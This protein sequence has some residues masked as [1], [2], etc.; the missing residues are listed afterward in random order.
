MY[1]QAAQCQCH[2]QHDISNYSHYKLSLRLMSVDQLRNYRLAEET[3]TARMTENGGGLLLC[4]WPV[5]FF[6]LSSDILKKFNPSL[7]GF[8]RG[9]GSKRKGFNMAVAGAKTSYVH[10]PSSSTR[11]T[12]WDNTLSFLEWLLPVFV[13]LQRDPSASPRSH[14]SNE[15]KYGETSHHLKNSKVIYEVALTLF[16]SFILMFRTHSMQEVNFEN[17]WKLV[18]VFV[19]ENDL[20]DYCTDQV[21]VL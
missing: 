10:P 8:S 1:V 9:Q 15:R 19:G 14:Q 18:T 2:I 20:C 3:L 21:S 11:V 17:D 12:P 5:F 7:K 13:L 16:P 6:F 4:W